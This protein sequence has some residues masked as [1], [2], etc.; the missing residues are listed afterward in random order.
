MRSHSHLTLTA[1]RI[2]TRTC[3]KDDVRQGIYLMLGLPFVNCSLESQ[4]SLGQKGLLEP[5]GVNFCSVQG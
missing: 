3:N 2:N 4:K 5:S 1:D